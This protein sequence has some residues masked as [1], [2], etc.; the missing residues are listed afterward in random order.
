MTSLA[1]IWAESN[2]LEAGSPVHLVVH[3]G[4]LYVSGGDLVFTARLPSSPDKFVLRAI[5]NVKVKNSGG[6]AFGNSGNFYVASRTER[7]ILKFDRD[8][9]PVK[10]YCDLPDD[11]EF[12]LH[13]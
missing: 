9:K 1:N 7:T 11:P 13:V 6:M 10:F 8:F 12:L 5:D 4:C 3:G 2:K